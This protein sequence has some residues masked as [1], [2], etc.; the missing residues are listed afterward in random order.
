MLFSVSIF[1]SYALQFYVLME[2]VGPKVIRPLVPEQWY[3]VSDYTTRIVINIIT[4]KC[5]IYYR[6]LCD[7]TDW[8]L[9]SVVRTQ[10]K[11]CRPI[12]G[13]TS[14]SIDLGKEYFTMCDK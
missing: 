10:T 6:T 1:F 7:V 2:I 5:R 12:V 11:D 4:C 3:S 13:S 8:D 9:N 14:A